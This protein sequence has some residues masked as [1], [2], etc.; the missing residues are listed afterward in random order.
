VLYGSSVGGMAKTRYILGRGRNGGI[1]CFLLTL[2]GLIT[3]LLSGLCGK[4]KEFEY[5]SYSG[6][7][8]IEINEEQGWTSYNRNLHSEFHNTVD[9]TFKVAS[10]KSHKPP[11]APSIVLSPYEI[12]PIMDVMCTC[13]APSA[14]HSLDCFK[15][16]ANRLLPVYKNACMSKDALLLACGL[17]LIARRTNI[18]LLFIL[19]LDENNR[20]C[21]NTGL[22][23]CAWKKHSRTWP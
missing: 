14:P 20:K 5:I 11:D 17:S 18:R 7:S 15:D 21:I 10:K 8:P 1:S 3:G 12:P 6:V 9:A 13:S 22:F 16:S 23:N 19:L 2:L 4:L